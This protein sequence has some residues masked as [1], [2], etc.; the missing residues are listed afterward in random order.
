[1]R[2]LPVDVHL[3]QKVHDDAKPHP[4]ALID[5]ITVVVRETNGNISIGYNGE[6]ITNKVISI[7]IDNN[8]N[9]II[10]D[11]QG[12]YTIK[13][14][15][16]DITISAIEDLENGIQ[17]YV[18]GEKYELA[19]FAV[20]DAVTLSGAFGTGATSEES[21]LSVPLEFTVDIL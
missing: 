19:K 20:F 6:I 13:K 3:L 4:P 10:S 14:I 8:T 18:K 21:L 15:N 1:M 2:Y 11:S 16:R 5:F 7:L 17:E 12:I 9:K